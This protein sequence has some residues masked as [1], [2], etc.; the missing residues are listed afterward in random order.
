MPIS[1]PYLLG[2]ATDSGVASLTITPSQNTA[3]G[4]TIIVAT[5]AD[6]QPN[7]LAEPQSVTDTA[8]NVYKEAPFSVTNNPFVSVWY[9]SNAAALTTASVITVTWTD[10]SDINAIAVGCT[11]LA[12]GNAVDKFVSNYTTAGSLSL[13]TGPLGLANELAIAYWSSRQAQGAPQISPDWNSFAQ[14]QGAA[15]TH[16]DNLAWKITDTADPLTA[17]ATTPAAGTGWTG[18]LITFRGQI[19]PSATLSCGGTLTGFPVTPVN[20]TATLHCGGSLLGPD[21]LAPTPPPVNPVFPAGYGPLPADFETWIR[22]SFTYCCEQTVFRAEQQA[23]GGQALTAA[24]FV[25]VQYDTVLEDP[26]EGW[27]ATSTG[28]QAAWSWLA[29]W[30]GLYRVT[31][32]YLTGAASGAYHNPAVGVSG[33][34]PVFEAGGVLAPTAIG[35]G[36]E[37]S[38]L[39]PLIGGTD[40]VQL[41]AWSAA[42]ATTD[43]STAGRRPSV[44]ITAV[45]TD[46]LPS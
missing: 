20:A 19:R 31:F 5:D 14:F 8:G 46:L 26:W 25:P 18:L 35:G 17:V 36:G 33:L 12:T 41:L 10:T 40:Y 3:A 28:G 24:A 6:L 42:A 16:W 27:S 22:R 9:S 34:N 2:T 1:N 15:N 44:E 11:G 43:T 21:E 38:A 29:P 32:R 45:Q 37:V 23:G 13:T 39:V 7:S 30:T 4:D